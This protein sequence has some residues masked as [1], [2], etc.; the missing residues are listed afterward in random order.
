MD[1]NAIFAILLLIV[2]LAILCAEIF[3]PSGGLLGVITFLTLLV[4]LLFAYRAWGTSHPNIFFAFCVMILLLVPVVVG[5]AFYLL[6]RTSYGKRILL[7]APE[8]QDLI[9]YSA[10]AERIEKLV[11]RFGL[12]LSML[13]PGG[14]VS[15]DGKRLHAVSEGLSIDPG[16]SIEIV[17]VQGS[18]VVVR[19]GTPPV[20][21][22]Q[23]ATQPTT[24]TEG[25]SVLDFD[26]PAGT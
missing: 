16:V 21:E 3:V 25:S 5:F 10:E 14:L 7:D 8:A 9:P 18:G 20:R 23:D 2:A 19:P 22:T 11:G 4:S 24:T 15:V 1:S 13:N 12:T 26:F 17:D 6:P